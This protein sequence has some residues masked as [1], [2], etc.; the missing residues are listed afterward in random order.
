[1]VYAHFITNALIAVQALSK[2]K[3]PIFA[4]IGE[5][6]I[7]DR[8]S[9]YPNNYFK[10]GIAQITGFVAVSSK[11]QKKLI[12]FGVDEN[13]I[14][15][16]PN[17][18]DLTKFDKKDKSTMRK[19]YNLPQDKNIIM[20][21]GRFIHHKGPLRILE[22]TKGMNGIGFIFVGSGKQELLDDRIFFKGK[23]P[24]GEVAGL[25]SCADL[26]VLP[27]LKEGSSNA[28]VE[29]MACGLPII[30]SDIPEVRDQCESSFSI[31]VDPMDK[32]AIKD[33]ITKVIFDTSK[34]IEMSENA[35]SYS[36]RFD[37]RERAKSILKFISTD[38]K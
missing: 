38:S 17:A 34:L 20:F 27:T 6:N 30:S 14:V 35:L 37:L 19:K 31:L 11:L 10:K 26:F 5:S 24:S 15:I 21:T 3:K 18:V 25:L 12:S 1:M 2:F 4:A 36:K 32:S 33:A 22:A 16:K 7:D 28:I 8:K 13:R 23:V 9:V 29:A